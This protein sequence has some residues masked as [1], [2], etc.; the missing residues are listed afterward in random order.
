M[1][2]HSSVL[3]QRIPG[4]GEPGGLPS[5]GRTESDPT[6]ATQQQQKETEKEQLDIE[7]TKSHN[8]DVLSG[9]RKKKKS[10]SKDRVIN[11]DNV[12]DT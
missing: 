10:V 11:C 9:R 12:A 3:A 4:M 2:I 1:A 7:G 8:C 6:E 5:M